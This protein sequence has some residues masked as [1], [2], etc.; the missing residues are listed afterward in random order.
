[1]TNGTVGG[2]SCAYVARVVR[3]GEVR[4]VARVAVT[5]CTCVHVVDMTLGAGGVEMHPGQRVVGIKSVVELCVQPVDG[6]VA[7]ATIMWQSELQMAW[8]VGRQKLRSVTCVA[9][10]RRP[11]KDVID[12][13]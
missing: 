7:T 13:A 9:R 4:F 11:F 5:G 1:M 10:G 3:P 6:G 2:K 12:V 8:V